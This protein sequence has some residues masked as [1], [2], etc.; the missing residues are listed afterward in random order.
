MTAVTK[1]GTV[2]PIMGTGDE[3]SGLAEAL[4]S[5]NR[6]AVLSLLNSYQSISK[7]PI[8][9]AAIIKGTTDHTGKFVTFYGD[10]LM[11]DL[12]AGTCKP[13]FRT[14]V[15]VIPISKIG[16]AHRRIHRRIKI[17][18]S[19]VSVKFLSVIINQRST[20]EK[21]WGD[22]RDAGGFHSIGI[23]VFPTGLS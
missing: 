14:I 1:K 21:R 11:E 19:S 13:A 4:F 17:P 22:Y 10:D 20:Y 6:R 8:S 16:M 2:V 23:F 15:F 12:V 7:I 18:I 5:K 3:T 9:D